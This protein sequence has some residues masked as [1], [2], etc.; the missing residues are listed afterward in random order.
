VVNDTANLLHSA[1]LHLLRHA[2]TVDVGMD[3]DGPRASLLSVL[4]FGG[5]QQ[6]TRLAEI[7]QVSPPAVTKLVTALEAAGLVSRAR[8]TDDRRV[9]V[10]SAT[11]AGRR[12]LH[13]GRA[14]RV[15]EI[16]RLLRGLPERDLATL[17]RAAVIID[18]VLAR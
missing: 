7:E 6:V 11:T 4:V 16:A 2:R 3:L 12:L 18:R 13:K 15:R 1:A 5:P 8:S 10:V 9:V 14:A 17:R